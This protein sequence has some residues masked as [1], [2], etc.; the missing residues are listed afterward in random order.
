MRI[1]SILQLAVFT[2][3]CLATAC[4]DETDATEADPESSSVEQDVS[5]TSLTQLFSCSTTGS[6]QQSF[7]NFNLAPDDG[8][9]VCVL[10]GIQGNWFGSNLGGGVAGI[11][12]VT[13][14][15][16]T[17]RFVLHMES[18]WG[19]NRTIKASAICTTPYA[20]EPLTGGTWKAG[21]SATFL[22][23]K[24]GLQCFLSFLS[25][26]TGFSH[27]TDSVS[28][29]QNPD[30]GSWFIGGSQVPGT[31]LS[32]SA[33]CFVPTGGALWG[34]SY[35][36]NNG[37]NTLPLAP[38]DPQGNGVACG[39]NTVAGAFTTSGDKIA[40]SYASA[41]NQWNVTLSGAHHHVEARCYN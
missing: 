3:P 38:N 15:D 39:L 35:T 4:I 17:R 33:T 11:Q 23:N 30:T 19:L 9:H 34:Y 28:V 26:F 32:A 37:T 25:N 13:N 5:S 27:S 18:G 40:L 8:Q 6:D 41:L 20:R 24:P 36:W 16:G 14:V 7:C 22:G 21:Q 1:H 10:A 31:T 12:T 29:F 2:V